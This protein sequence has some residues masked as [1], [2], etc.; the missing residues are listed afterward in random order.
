MKEDILDLAIKLLNDYADILSRH[1]IKGLT[2]TQQ[3]EEI[4]LIEHVID[5]LEAR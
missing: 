1:R 2:P 5:E 4:V 3:K